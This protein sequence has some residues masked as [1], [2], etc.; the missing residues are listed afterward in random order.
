MDITSWPQAFTAVGITVIVVAGMCFF[1]WLY[2]RDM[3]DD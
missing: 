2:M 1:V 3:D